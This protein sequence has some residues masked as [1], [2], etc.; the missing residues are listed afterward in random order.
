[1]P[2]VPTEDEI[3]LLL[4]V[5]SPEHRAEA[6]ALLASWKKAI[7]K[8]QKGPQQAAF[9]SIAD[10]L[11]YG[12]S[13][14]GGKTSLILGKALT[15]H[16]KSMILRPVGTELTAIRD[17]I[18]ALVGNTDG[19]N[20]R[21]NIWRLP[22]GRQIELGA[23]PDVGDERKF[24]GRP[25]DLL[26]FDEAA[27][28][29]E[30]AVRFLM[31]W[32]R[33]TIK[34][35]R[36][37]AIL[38]FN[39]PTTVEGRWVIRFF[40]PWLDPKHPNPAEPGEIRWFCV[41]VDEQGNSRDVEVEDER[42]RIQEGNRLTP[43]FD[44]SKVDPLR[45][46]KPQSRTFIPSRVSDNKYLMGTGYLAQ[47]QALPEPLRSQML[48]GDFQAGVRDDEWQIIPTAW[49]QAAMDRWSADGRDTF[50]SSLGVD[51]ARGGRDKFVIAKRYDNWI[52]P[53]L[54]YPGKDTPDGQFVLGLVQK[55]LFDEPEVHRAIVNIDATGVGTSPTDLARAEGLRVN[56]VIF[57]AGTSAR[58]RAG[59]MRMR[60][61]RAW[62]WW[63]LRDALDPDRGD[64]LAL[65]PDPELLADLTS[66]RWKPTMS[67]VQVEDKEEI[68]KRIGRS[69]D[70]GEAVVLACYPMAPMQIVTQRQITARRPAYGR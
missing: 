1:M 13:A 43:D 29:R 33:T 14:G 17:D 53:L 9:E 52:G 66:A 50:L 20:G 51:V 21:D 10:V 23:I 62:L 15:A 34:G 65:P 27:N 35:Q 54:K 56:A 19:Y 12:G 36:C 11:G 41:L 68:I 39:P 18:A 44:P 69:P 61:V 3:P 60:N 26:A 58:D 7:W 46:L 55:A 8:P 38:A 30:A 48:Y 70:C 4:E 25:H 28:F 22:D 16:R 47:L 42:P 5:M 24:Q 63:H 59:L 64:D 37:Q 32:L 31:T 45:I 40:A 49:V 57:G 67:G 2:R 6:V